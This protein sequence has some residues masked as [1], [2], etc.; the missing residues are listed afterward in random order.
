MR[1]HVGE[2]AIHALSEKIVGKF[3]L[4]KSIV[5]YENFCAESVG[6]KLSM[7][8]NLLAAWITCSLMRSVSPHV[9]QC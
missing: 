1:I 8:T 4:P 9:G 3:T 2:C 6:S 7:T 5:K